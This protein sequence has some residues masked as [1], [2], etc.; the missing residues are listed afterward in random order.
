MSKSLPL[1]AMFAVKRV[2]IAIGKNEYSVSS[3][4]KDLYLGASAGLKL[5]SIINLPPSL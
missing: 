1:V 3:S 2:P 5:T 4:Q